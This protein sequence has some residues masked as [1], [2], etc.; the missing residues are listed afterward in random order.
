MTRP[1][2]ESGFGVVHV[3]FGAS[4]TLRTLTAAVVLALAT[5][6]AASAGLV[7]MHVRDVPLGPRALSSARPTA[8]FDM[9]AGLTWGS[10]L[11]DWTHS[12]TGATA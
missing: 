6:A 7:S 10:A 1:G 2:V 9:G 5:P 4:L 8:P 12:T 11:I 3:L